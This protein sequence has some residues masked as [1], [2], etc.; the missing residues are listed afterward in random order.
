MDRSKLPP[1]KREELRR[2]EE[3]EMV[4]QVY[5]EFKESFDSDNP[6][7]KTF[8]RGEVVNPEETNAS[9]SS[10]PKLY[11]PAPVINRPSTGASASHSAD[12]ERARR[13]AEEKARKIMNEVNKNRPAKPGTTPTAR[14]N[15]TSNLEAFKEELR[16]LQEAR[17]ER[18]QVR[19]QL[20]EQLGV[21]SEAIDRIAPSLDNPY[22]GGAY[23]NDPFTTNLFLS[24]LSPEITLEDL[25]EHFGSFGPLASAK[26]MWPRS[27]EERARGY[28][29]GF[30]A[31]MTR[32]DT[33]R[34][35]AVLKGKMIKGLEMKMSWAKPVPIPNQPVY[36]PPNM[37]ELMMP[38]P[39]SGLPFNAQPKKSQKD[40]YMA[41]WNTLPAPGQPP[42][43]SP[44]AREEW[45][46]MI[47]NA[48]VRVVIP[49]ER[50]LLALIHRTI[51]YV[52]REGPVFEAML[53][54]RE[55]SNPMFRFLFDNQ[56]PA[57]V[58]YRWKLFSILQGD[59][60]NKWSL[61]EFRMF[62]SGSIWQPPP[63]DFFRQGMP[64][65]LYNT[66]ILADL[67]LMKPEKKREKRSSSS[68]SSEES[69]EA[70][71]RRSRSRSPSPRSPSP[72]PKQPGRGTLSN[73]QRDELE[74]ILRGLIPER[75][76]IEEAMMWCVEH[77]SCALEVA[78]CAHESLTIDE[79]PLHKKIARLYLIADILANCGAPRIR[80]VFYY[81]QFLGE[82]MEDIFKQMHKAYSRIEARLKAEQFKQRVIACFRTWEE[83]ALYPTDI[84]IRLQN[85]FLGLVKLDEDVAEEVEEFVDEDIDGEPLDS[86]APVS[87]L[88]AYD[89]DGAPMDDD[90]T[91][92]DDD[93]KQSAPKGA[94][95][96]SKWS[97][98]DPELIEQQAMTTSKWDML[99]TH[100]DDDQAEDEKPAAM[101][102]VDYDDDL[103]GVP[104]ED[105]GG[106]PMA[107]SSHPSTSRTMTHS[108]AAK[109]AMSEERRQLLRDIEMKVVKFQD[110]L[111]SG[112]SQPK[113]NSS[114]AQE[115]ANYRSRLLE[116][117]DKPAT[118]HSSSKE[119]NGKEKH[120]K[121]K[122]RKEE[123][124]KRRKRSRSRSKSPS[125]K[126]SKRSRSRSRSPSKSSSRRHRR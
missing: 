31:F 78:E 88:V 44:D 2:K 39:P 115:V 67:E 23:D 97:E 32:T 3:E 28:L 8:I 59:A 126:A 101:G 107:V 100:E 4:K 57:H 90:D 54:S 122:K 113:K 56:H 13:L 94:F 37:L 64:E 76:M 79:T 108:T 104:M 98:V 43:T 86:S 109:E 123:K 27:E 20:Q 77:A 47:R 55:M 81:R 112:R 52:I 50:P 84:L 36:A 30:I 93:K 1:H 18:R 42:P 12:F 11:K 120:G 38:D 15:R 5:E 121:E 111:E 45:Q 91:H 58:Y 62:E 68:S 110:D 74:D 73:R 117:I 14:G 46:Q 119:R 116:E 103:D 118:D 99:E 69:E 48:T 85:I 102:I 106:K 40:A 82:R 35:V 9:H 25:Y 83:N 63:M 26:I 17:S 124:E 71:R 72:R 24:N 53:M 19:Q 80:D 65:Q 75:K 33:D 6:I 70:D 61:K 29:C 114:V 105:D 96:A 60:P 66:A 10:K 22:L 51:E 34:S 125:R 89:I 7:N 95:K 41:R 49:T 21:D 87:K 16:V 92:S